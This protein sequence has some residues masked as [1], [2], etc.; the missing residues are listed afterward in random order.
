MSESKRILSIK[1][2]SILAGVFVIIILIL[3]SEELNG[4]LNKQLLISENEQV[5]KSNLSQHLMKI[6]SMFLKGDYLKALEYYNSNID[7]S[8]QNDSVILLRTDLSLLL[9]QKQKKSFSD[10][11]YINTG[12]ESS[13]VTAQEIKLYDSV[14][15]A[16]EKAKA[17]VENM[18]RQLTNKSFGEYLIFMSEKGNEIHYLGQV[19]K[20]KANGRG[21][22][23]FSTGS[24]YEGE[25]KEN[26]RHGNG[27]FYWFDGQI[28]KGG[29]FEDKRN[30]IGTYSW[31]NGDTFIGKWA[32]DKRNGEGT[33]Y[34]KDGEIV[35]TG[36]WKDDNL[37]NVKKDKK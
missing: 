16:L 10:T 6:D 29:Y 32:N 19:K 18:K 13:L 33:F 3:R 35:A 1:N 9:S 30:G 11:V 31:P 26:K 4:K 8:I 24:R 36:L 15:F 23:I 7:L 5:T 27:S 34:N 2:S 14:A 22:A 28:Y 12:S 25:W 17:Q 20:G 37:I 21:I